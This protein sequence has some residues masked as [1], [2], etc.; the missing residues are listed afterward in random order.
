MVNLDFLADLDSPQ[1]KQKPISVPADDVADVD[2]DLVPKEWLLQ[3]FKQANI[4]FHISKSVLVAANEAMGSGSLQQ[5][6]VPVPVSCGFL[7]AAELHA[8]FAAFSSGSLC[9]FA[10]GGYP[11]A[12]RKLLYF[13][14]MPGAQEPVD[15]GEV[16]GGEETAAEVDSVIE[17]LPSTEFLEIAGNFIFEKYTAAELRDWLLEWTCRSGAA[18]GARVNPAALGDIIVTGSEGFQLVVTARGSAYEESLEPTASAGLETVGGVRRVL[19]TVEILL[20]GL[21]DSCSIGSVPIRCRVIAKDKLAV[22]PPITK[23]V[24]GIL[25]TSLLIYMNH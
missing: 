13:Y 23:E 5:L 17:G 2:A 4:P 6:S 25:H 1:S 22:R 15:G 12:E 19:S 11:Q 20:E 7:S 16:K 10:D 24:H 14:R 18:S 21:N 8:V 9:V 3:Q